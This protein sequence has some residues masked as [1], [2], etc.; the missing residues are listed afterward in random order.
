MIL[1]D[2][3][4]TNIK[5]DKLHINCPVRFE[6]TDW[7]IHEQFSFRL[8]MKLWMKELS[9]LLVPYVTFTC[10]AVTLFLCFCRQFQQQLRKSINYVRKWTAQCCCCICGNTTT[11]TGF[12]FLCCNFLSW[13]ILTW[14]ITSRRRRDIFINIS[15]LGFNTENFPENT[16]KMEQ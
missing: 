16:S 1:K 3:P 9:K 10:I 2:N 13:R 5:H 12:C 7:Q 15:K 11:A 8:W 14:I 6:K 4:T